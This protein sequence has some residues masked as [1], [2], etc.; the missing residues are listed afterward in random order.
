MWQKQQKQ[1]NPFMFLYTSFCTSH[2]KVLYAPLYLF[3]TFSIHILYLSS[4]SL[5]LF[6]F[7]VRTCSGLFSTCSGLV[8]HFSNTC[9][10]LPHGFFRSCSLLF[11][12]GSGLVQ[13]LFRI[14]WRIVQ[15]C[16]INCWLRLPWLVQDLYRTC[17]RLFHDLFRTFLDLFMTFSI[18]VQYVSRTLSVLSCSC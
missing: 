15:D 17:L 14:W 6:Q 13:G 18:I 2:L 11:R 8:H 12:T 16:F 10:G 7:F 1:Q 3:R 4:T 9:S 5:E